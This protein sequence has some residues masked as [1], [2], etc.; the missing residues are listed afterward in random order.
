M[1]SH[2]P[3]TWRKDGNSVRVFVA[4]LIL[5]LIGCC[6]CSST[7]NLT[8]HHST[9][10]STSTTHSASTNSAV[11]SSTVTEQASGEVTTQADSL[12]TT[13][14]LSDTDTIRAESG[15]I[16]IE[17]TKDPVTH[18]VKAKAVAKAK[19]VPF[20][21]N[22]TTVTNKS[23]G[24]TVKTDQTI[25]VKSTDRGKEVVKEVSGINWNWLWLILSAV[26]LLELWHLGW[27]R[28]KGGG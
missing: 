27:F 17:V 6:S 19:V 20:N 25:K 10:D 28:K 3:F 1:Q 11:T 9:T 23:E 2:I 26:I 12:T 14:L 15:G 7:K 22:K 18:K 16:R 21:I 13:G 24:G 8:K 4:I 5:F